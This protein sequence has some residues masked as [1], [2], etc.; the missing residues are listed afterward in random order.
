MATIQHA[1]KRALY[2]LLSLYSTLQK[3]SQYF[4]VVIDELSP[5]IILDSD[6]LVK[7]PVQPW[8]MTCVKPRA[9]RSRGI[10]DDDDDD[11]VDC[12]IVCAVKFRCIVVGSGTIIYVS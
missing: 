9:L 2:P 1:M 5:V 7:H 8:T 12:R 6:D 11:D 3:L 10:D 4:I